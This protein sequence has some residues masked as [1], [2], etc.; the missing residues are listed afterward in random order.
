MPRDPDLTPN[1][2]K[3]SVDIVDVIGD[4]LTLHP[5]G[6]KFRVLCPFHDDHRP[7][8][9]VSPE[10]QSYK[11]WS[12]G[13]GGDV[14]DFVQN[15]E[16]VDFPEALKLLAERAGIVLNSVESG[17]HGEAFSH[18]KRLR[19]SALDQIASLYAQALRQHRDSGESRGY[20]A[21]RGFDDQS[22]TRFQLGFAPEQPGWLIDQA[23][24]LGLDREMLQIL[25]LVTSG[26]ITPES[27]PRQGGRDR[28]RGRLMFPIRDIQGRTVGFGGRI[29]PSLKKRLEDGGFHVA[30]YLNS[31]DSDLFQKRTLLF[32]ADLARDSARKRGWVAVVEG[33]TDVIAAHQ[34]GL[35]NVVATLGTA[36]GEEHIRLLKRLSDSV[37]L[38]FDGDEA[39]QSAA[40]RSL[41]LFLRHEI[42]LR[43]LCLEPGFDPCDF[44][45]AEGGERFE[46]KLAEAIDPLRFLIRR[47]G[48][49]F[50]LGQIES[51]RQAA[52]W[53]LQ[54]VADVPRGRGPSQAID[55]KL[56][57]ALDQLGVELR[58]PA[59]QLHRRWRALTRPDRSTRH[60][61]Q[62]GSPT[63]SVASSAESRSVSR[64][65][66]HGS[67]PN[68]LDGPLSIAEL[69]SRLD[70]VDRELLQIVLSTPEV[71]DQT[72][73]RSRI[74]AE[75][76][77]SE[78][79]RI[80]LQT[81]YRL[82]GQGIRP[83]FSA[84]TSEL[85]DARLHALTASLIVPAETG[86]LPPAETGP[87]PEQIRSAP[88]ELR[89]AGVLDQMALRHWHD[90]LHDI[91]VALSEIDPVADP[92]SARALRTERL[93]ILNQRPRRHDASAPAHAS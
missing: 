87:L 61:N 12:C 11:C 91:D 59:D 60:P 48:Q 30:K 74:P 50:D 88:W 78:P 25:G 34:A 16:K 21:E 73:L 55:L 7:S 58:I 13:A 90:R 66:T 22:V 67:V 76:L 92:D 19:R 45:M 6:S 29:L 85:E 54:I 17:L 81:C 38:V 46:A 36:L 27:I 71:L 10:H 70:P 64:G 49:R 53:V 57:R 82:H 39:G 44:L 68:S 69:E 31:P 37:V 75:S 35:S 43:V 51:S 9:D 62:A 84:I 72:E 33:Y 65:Q 1:I 15:Y 63:K 93:R 83:E 23:R 80:L 28:F 52:D 2:I 32:G 77:R 14:L 24:R 26:S 86:P 89:L 41:S 40:D 56:A 4:V 3:Q 8:M 42:D 18:S 5:A 20:L 47:A 79:A